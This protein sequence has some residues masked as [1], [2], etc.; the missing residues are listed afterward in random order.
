MGFGLPS[1]IGFW[2]CKTI[3]AEE[4]LKAEQSQRPINILP[5]D[6]VLGSLFEAPRKINFASKHLQMVASAGRRVFFKLL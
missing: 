1:K 3:L 5:L 2:I 4:R 6:K